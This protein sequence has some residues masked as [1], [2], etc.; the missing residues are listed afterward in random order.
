MPEEPLGPW[1]PLDLDH[2]VRLFAQWPGHWWITGG[3]ALE[4]HLG[5]SWRAHHDSDLSIVRRETPLLRTVLRDWDIQI[6]AAGAL[7]PWEG[8]EPSAPAN[9]N[10]LWC[11]QAPDQPWCLDVTLSD[12]DEDWWIYRRDPSLRRP[13][14]DAVLRTDDGVPYLDP[15]LQLLFK[16]KDHRPKDDHDARE[17]VPALSEGQ[18]RELR[19]LLPKD[20]AWQVLLAD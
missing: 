19:R 5:R 11:R 1:E 10:N 20:H 2:V 12:G 18:R 3:V 16:S 7:T 15:V 6:A 14:S 17:V 4:L 9:Q 13:W 8:T